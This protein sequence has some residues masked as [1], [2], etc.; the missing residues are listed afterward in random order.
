MITQTVEPK[1]SADRSKLAD[2]LA[3][4]GREDPTLVVKL[5]EESGATV[6]QGMGE[7]HLEI[8]ASRLRRDFK[9]E[10]RIGTQ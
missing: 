4:L 1:S 3:A 10:V 6:I 2:A 9:I 7:L 5:D 8:L